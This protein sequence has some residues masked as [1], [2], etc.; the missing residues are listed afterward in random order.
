[1]FDLER[2][3]PSELGGWLTGKFT[4]RVREN[5]E[6]GWDLSET[7]FRLYQN[8]FYQ[9]QSR[10]F[11]FFT[12]STHTHTHTHTALQDRVFHNPQAARLTCY[13]SPLVDTLSAP[14]FTA[15][16]RVRIVSVVS[17][18]LCWKAPRDA[19]P[20]CCLKKQLR[21][22]SY[23]Q[24]FFEIYSSIVISFSSNIFMFT[25]VAPYLA[26]FRRNF[27]KCQGRILILKKCR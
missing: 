17:I 22:H 6:P 12:F 15:V 5:L 25:A 2:S 11:F 3:R 10:F 23:V 18:Q 26:K 8:R 20:L 24:Y 1:M 21:S 19:G 27:I 9:L 4:I 16:L 13:L 14:Y 7:R